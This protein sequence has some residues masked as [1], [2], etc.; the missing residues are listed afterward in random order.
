[1]DKEQHPSNSNDR[2]SDKKAPPQGGNVVWYMLGLG[3]LLLLMVMMFT[4]GTEVEMHWSD[5]ERLI[6]A[7]DPTD[8]NATKSIEIVDRS[9][10]PEQKVRVGNLSHIVIGE[11]EVTAQV[12]R[13]RP[14]A[15]GTNVSTNPEATDAA[16]EARDEEI[17]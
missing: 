13:T 7:S 5:F 14:K 17:K 2:S 9:R 10:T 16:H 12:T 3:V 15:T 8:D 4:T 6:A 1:M 11:R